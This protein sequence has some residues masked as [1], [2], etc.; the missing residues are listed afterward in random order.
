MF[1]ACDEQVLPI[2]NKKYKTMC[3]YEK[4]LFEDDTI[5]L[6]KEYHFG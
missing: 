4:G 1:W 6:V 2:C 3:W 5:T